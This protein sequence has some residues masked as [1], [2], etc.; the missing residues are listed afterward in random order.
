VLGE[1]DI[2]NNTF[3]D[4]A[5]SV[6]PRDAL[7]I[8]VTAIVPCNQNGQ[9]ISTFTEGTVAYLK[10]TVSSNSMNSEPLLLTINTYDYGA[11]TIGVISFNG[12]T[13]PGE[14]TFLLGSPVP[15]NAR[16]G[17]ATVYVNA[18]TN[19]PQFGG[20]AYGPEKVATYQIVGR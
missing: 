8:N 2:L 14:T 15:I 3:T 1:T 17:Q 12:P 13:A 9:P 19:W 11:N 4:G 16:T 7:F 20:V 6:L 5:V 10:I 18:L